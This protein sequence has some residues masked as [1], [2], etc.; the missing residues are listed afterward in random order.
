[1]QGEQDILV[2]GYFR[3]PHIAV[4]E[5]GTVRTIFLQAR[6]CVTKTTADGLKVACQMCC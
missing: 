2:L 1:M 5:V 3:Q 6:R 4:P